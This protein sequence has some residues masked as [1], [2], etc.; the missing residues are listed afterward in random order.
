MYDVISGSQTVSLLLYLYS[1]ARHLYLSRRR[2]NAHIGPF[3][4]DSQFNS[5]LS[6]RAYSR[7]L[8]PRASRLYLAARVQFPH[9]AS[10]FSL[11]QASQA[12]RAHRSTPFPRVPSLLSSRARYTAPPRSSVAFISAALEWGSVDRLKSLGRCDG[13]GCPRMGNVDG[14]GSFSIHGDKPPV[15]ILALLCII[16]YSAYTKPG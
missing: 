9:L 12:P 6:S 10:I 13:Q 5:T 16:S 1:S 15:R 14:M 7:P 4:G 2:K 11:T 3:L 8:A